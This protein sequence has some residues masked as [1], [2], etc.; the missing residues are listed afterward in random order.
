ME[1]MSANQIR[2]VKEHL[3]TDKIANR[4]VNCVC[5]IGRGRFHGQVIYK[6]GDF[7]LK[8]KDIGVV[9]KAMEKEGYTSKVNKDSVGS[10]WANPSLVN[11]NC[12]PMPNQTRALQPFKRGKTVF[13]LKVAIATT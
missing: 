2:T 9:R 11:T 6:D 3:G 5:K 4:H 7:Y 1:K 8:S 12:V 10:A 13:H